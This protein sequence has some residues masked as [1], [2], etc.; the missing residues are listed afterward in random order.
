MQV[1][2]I[3]RVGEVPVS[4]ICNNVQEREYD[5]LMSEVYDDPTEDSEYVY[6]FKYD[7]GLSEVSFKPFAVEAISATR[8]KP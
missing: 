7:G 8:S 5:Q 3:V 1:T 2:L 4:F 6:T